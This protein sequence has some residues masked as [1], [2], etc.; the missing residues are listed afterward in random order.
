MRAMEW[1]RQIA[2]QAGSRYKFH[3]RLWYA[4]TMNAQTGIHESHDFIF[5]IHCSINS[6]RNQELPVSK[7]NPRGKQFR[8]SRAG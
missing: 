7:V 8:I 3:G 1:R 4:S 2:S 6:N 5:P